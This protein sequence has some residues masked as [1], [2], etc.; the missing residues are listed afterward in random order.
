MLPK[1]HIILGL[2][3]SALVYIIF[4]ITFFQAF[5]I[6]F[7][8]V[9]IDFDHY[10]WYVYKKKDFNLKNALKWFKRK[11][12][13][14]YNTPHHKLRNIKKSILVF[15]G[16]E[17]IFILSILSYFNNLFIYLI[18]GT[19]YHLVFDYIELI[20][21]KQPLYTKFSQIIVLIKDK[22]KLEIDKVFKF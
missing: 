17:F 13:I 15:H 22:N 5:L 11:R 18:I 4:H 2:I 19:L 8:S 1:T 21:L 16:V 3:F 20:Q 7:A 10:V 6:F 9:F 12:D 14:Y